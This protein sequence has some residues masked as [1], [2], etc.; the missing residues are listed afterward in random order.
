MLGIIAWRKAS[1]SAAMQLQ[2]YTTI[3]LE[4]TLGYGIIEWLGLRDVLRGFK[5]P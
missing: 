4:Y 1:G 2:R 3:G 5:S